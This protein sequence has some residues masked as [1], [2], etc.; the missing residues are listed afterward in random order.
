M[1]G[2]FVECPRYIHSRQVSQR[3]A[4]VTAKAKTRRLRRSPKSADGI[5][6]ADQVVHQ[7][8]KEK[9][10]LREAEVGIT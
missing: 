3:L 2:A 10:S 9:G 1:V 6:S 5:L 8:S 7:K 4:N